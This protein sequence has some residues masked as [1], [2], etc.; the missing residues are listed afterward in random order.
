MGAHFSRMKLIS[1]PV[2]TPAF[3][4]LHL[5]RQLNVSHRFWGR[6]VFSFEILGKNRQ[7][8]EVFRTGFSTLQKRPSF[9]VTLFE[10]PEPDPTLVMV[11]PGVSL[12]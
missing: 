8:F 5:S 9:I 12:Y 3:L 4:H 10:N 2:T 1:S 6:L 11:A 7:P